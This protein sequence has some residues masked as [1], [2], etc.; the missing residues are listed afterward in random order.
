MAQSNSEKLAL[1]LSRT[2]KNIGQWDYVKASHFKADYLDAKKLWRQ[3]IKI[4]I[5]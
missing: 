4:M 5:K 2:P 3:K 1:M